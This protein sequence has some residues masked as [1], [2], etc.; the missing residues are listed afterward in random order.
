MA[1]STHSSI[2]NS[3]QTKRLDAL[4]HLSV[5]LSAQRSVE[6][7]LNT[8]L[9]QCLELTD[10]QFGF[11]GLT[12]NQNEELDVVA[13]VGFEMAPDFYQ[14]NHIIPL[15]PNIFSF[16]IL[17]DKAI[18]TA[19]AR[20]DPRRVGQPQDHPPVNTFLGVPLRMQ[21]KP[22]GMIGVANRP[23]EYELE[24][25]QLLTTYAAQVAILIR[26]AQLYD[27]LK[28]TNE[29]LEKMVADR[30]AALQTA[31]RS[32][33]K[34][35]TQLQSLFTGTVAV[36]E[37]ERKR[38]ALEMHDGVNQLL[39]GAMY[40]LSSADRRISKGSLEKASDSIQ[41]V[42]HILHQVEEEIKRII[43]DLRPPTLDELGLI[44][45][46]NK[47][48]YNHSQYTKSSCV[49]KTLGDERRLP[50][51]T[52]VNV[53]RAVQEAL[54]NIG[55]HADAQNV[56][57]IL[58]FSQNTLKTTI[59]DDGVGFDVAAVQLNH[60]NHLGLLSMRER[61]ESLG[62]RFFIESDPGIGTR[63][64]LTFPLKGE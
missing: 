1:M 26:N 36:Q 56:S 38:I 54:H 32:L 49:L 14:S 64:E 7:V 19:D 8:A 5:E 55:V 12:I 24:H 47:L 40:E 42:Q 45:T 21:D 58:A 4:Y 44:P 30:T 6:S 60:Q 27:E 43:Y 52:E 15:R 18:R 10:S 16:V 23:T 50:S 41:S 28:A 17:N 9:Q 33:A 2:S 34:K 48:V 20:V 13:T 62:G 57:I 37:E 63:I 35:A 46:L 11:I 29:S 59:S 3:H 53:Y 31:Q 61:A 22:I 25:E 51:V 39:Y